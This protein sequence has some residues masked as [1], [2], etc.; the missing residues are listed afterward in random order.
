VLEGFLGDL[1]LGLGLLV[2]DE[3]E[4]L[5]LKPFLFMFMLPVEGSG[6]G[7]VLPAKGKPCHATG[8]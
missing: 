1:Q 4:N 2:G 7:I 8:R 5:A 3:V 6:V